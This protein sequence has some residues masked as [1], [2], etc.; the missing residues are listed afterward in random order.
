MCI[1]IEEKCGHACITH[2]YAIEFQ[3]QGLP[4][5]SLIVFER[6]YKLISSEVV[7]SS[8]VLNDQIL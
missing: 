3:K 6:K 8:L 2:V 5:T 1:P 4:H 7:N